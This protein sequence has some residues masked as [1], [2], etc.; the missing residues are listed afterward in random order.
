MARTY[1]FDFDGVL[2]DSLNYYLIGLNEALTA[3]G[4]KQVLTQK[5]ISE[6]RHLSFETLVDMFSLSRS[7]AQ[8]CM[9]L[10]ERYLRESPPTLVPFHG[11][12]EMLRNLPK[13]ADIFIVSLSN[14]CFIRSFLHNYQLDD[15]VD[16]VFGG[17]LRGDKIQKINTIIERRDINP[18]TA[19]MVGDAASDIAAAKACGIYSIGALWGW[20]PELVQKSEPDMT[21]ASVDKLSECLNHWCNDKVAMEG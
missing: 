1:F 13:D 3:V 15:Y 17:D 16:A 11:I 12:P 18:E 14:S 6:A 4:V 21:V 7:D 5:D 2:A 10:L 8:V 9:T 19:L 20:Q